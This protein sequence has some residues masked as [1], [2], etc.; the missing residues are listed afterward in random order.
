MAPGGGCSRGFL[1]LAVPSRLGSSISGDA[2]ASSARVVERVDDG[3]LEQRAGDGEDLASLRSL[4]LVDARRGF[5]EGQRSVRDLRYARQNR[6]PAP[7]GSNRLP[8]RSSERSDQPAE[9]HDDE[10]Q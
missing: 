7:V 1:L 5:F 3:L 8:P 4:R 6:E 10:A 9:N 2:V